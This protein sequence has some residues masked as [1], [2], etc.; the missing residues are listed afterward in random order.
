MS[1]DFQQKDTINSISNLNNSDKLEKGSKKTNLS[2]Y[3]QY[4]SSSFLT[5]MTPTEIQG[6]N[7]YRE[8]SYGLCCSSKYKVKDE[9]KDEYYQALFNQENITEEDIEQLKNTSNLSRE[10]CFKRLLKLEDTQKSKK[11][12]QFL[13]ALSSS[14]E[15]RAVNM[16]VKAFKDKNMSARDRYDLLSNISNFDLKSN[17]LKNLGR[18]TK[19]QYFNCVA[20]EEIKEQKNLE[21]R[22]KKVEFSDKSNVATIKNSGDYL[23]KKEEN[24]IQTKI[25]D[26]KLT[27]YNKD[28]EK[29][30]LENIIR[31]LK[32]FN[33]TLKEI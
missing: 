18:K 9:F 30:D 16:G 13:S 25:H 11:L 15:K 4:F 26:G 21:P 8:K 12:G 10:G 5:K 28:K 7:K 31:D 14:D 6:K 17:I 2:H 32:E 22:G 23:I 24:P 1:V 29:I 27:G 20:K 33:I 19:L 3:H